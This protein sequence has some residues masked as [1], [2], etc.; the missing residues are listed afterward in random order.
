[1]RVSPACLH[2]WAAFAEMVLAVVNWCGI[3]ELGCQ[4]R[5]AIRQRMHARIAR[6]RHG[7]DAADSVEPADGG[8]LTTEQLDRWRIE[9]K[10]EID[11]AVDLV[12]A[13]SLSREEGGCR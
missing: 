13:R 1:M 5:E 7:E 11:R 3:V 9:L 12:I 4:E 6:V 2:E 10:A 8:Y